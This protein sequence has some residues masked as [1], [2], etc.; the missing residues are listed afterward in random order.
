MKEALLNFL[1]RI[2]L[3]DIKPPVFYKLMKVHGRELNG[4]VYELAA[5][6]DSLF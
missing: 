5:D 1:H 6:P 4:W 3:T 2:V